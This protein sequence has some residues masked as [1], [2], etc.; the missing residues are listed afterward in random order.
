MSDKITVYDIPSAAKKLAYTEQY[1]RHLLRR[2]ELK[3]KLVPIAKG[4]NVRK[5]IITE[6]EIKRFEATRSRQSRRTD[7]RT[8][9]IQY[10]TFEEMEGIIKLLE[11]N[12]YEEVAGFIRPANKLKDIPKWLETRLNS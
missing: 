7:G 5:H 11:E 8:K 4:A 3:S 10:S 2:G 12:G 9:W 1:I 6:E